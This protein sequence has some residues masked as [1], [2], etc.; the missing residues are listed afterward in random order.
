MTALLNDITEARNTSVQVKEKSLADA[1][2]H[3]DEVKQV[4]SESPI[5]HKIS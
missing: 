1:R 3:F 4:L 5:F 2:Q